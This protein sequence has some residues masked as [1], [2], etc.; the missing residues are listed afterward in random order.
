VANDITAQNLAANVR[1]LR[2]AR[3]V[4][5][6]QIAQMAGIPRPTWANIESGDANP[7]LAVLTRV[8]AALGTHIEEL[9]VSPRGTTKHWPA[10]SLPIHRQGRASVKSFLEQPGSGLIVRR[11]V[12]QPGATLPVQPHAPQMYAY[13]TCEMGELHLDLQHSEHVLAAGDLLTFRADQ[14]YTYRNP[15]RLRGVGFCVVS[16]VKPSS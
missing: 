10:E 12:L 5:Q 11:I 6:Q 8:A 7:T 15:T 14:A 13:L 2:E 4:S 1:A 16:H 9:L 3:G